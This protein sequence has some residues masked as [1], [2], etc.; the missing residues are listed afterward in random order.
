VSRC[1]GGGPLLAGRRS[2]T[3]WLLVLSLGLASCGPAQ[4]VED[5]AETLPTW[6]LPTAAA[7]LTVTASASAT[8]LASSVPTAAPKSTDT[9]TPVP[10]ATPVP[11]PVDLVVLHTND[12]WG[13]TDPCG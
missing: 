3:V 5:E 12:N 4:Q 8:A 10:T 11:E 6:T 7:K 1:R 13:E 9:P 2:W